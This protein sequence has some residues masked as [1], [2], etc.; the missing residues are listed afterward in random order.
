MRVV[1]KLL[2]LKRNKTIINGALF[3]I[4][5][6]FGQGVSFVL[7][8]ILAKYIL[9]EEYGYLS[10]FTTITSILSIIFG[11][12]TSGYNGTIFFKESRTSFNKYFT[13][14]FLL[15]IFAIIPYSL[16]L[17]IC[18]SFLSEMLSL[19][20]NVLYMAGFLVI[21]NKCFSFHQELYRLHENLKMYGILSCSNA[22]MN[23]ITALFFV[24]YLQLNW[25]GRI[26]SLI[27]YS[28]IYAIIACIYFQ[29][30]HYIDFS[31]LKQ[32][33]L[34]VLKWGLPLVPHLAANWIKN[35][36]DRYIINDCH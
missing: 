6:F 1:G 36:L 10:L 24:V 33:V 34:P 12:G 11:L 21:F 9:P 26:Y 17:L 19:Q 30:N 5:S 20:L 2:S 27:T 31:G 18:G 7:L 29:K 28:A 32:R 8:I 4:F 35:G 23:F 13:A 16:I 25:I 3:S 22:I 14:V 15:N